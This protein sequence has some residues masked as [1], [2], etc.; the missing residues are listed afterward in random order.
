MLKRGPVVISGW[1]GPELAHRTAERLPRIHLS[2]HDAS[3]V[4]ARKTVQVQESGEQIFFIEPALSGRGK[5]RVTRGC[6]KVCVAAIL[7][8]S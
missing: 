7:S 8:R 4:Q 5:D 6:A 1:D 3:P 2:T